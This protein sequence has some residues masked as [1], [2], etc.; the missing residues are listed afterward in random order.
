MAPDG[1]FDDG[2]SKASV[3]A[4][5]G[6]RPGK[7]RQEPRTAFAEPDAR[8]PDGGVVW[9]RVSASEVTRAVLVALVTAAVVLGSFLLLWEVRSFVGWFVISLFLAAALDPAVGWLQRRHGLIGR[10][11]ATC[12]STWGWRSPCSSWWVSSCPCWWTRSKVSSSSSP[13]WPGRPRG[14]RRFCEA[15]PNVTG[16]AGCSRGSATNSATRAVSW[17]T[18]SAT[19]SC[20]PVTSSPAPP[21][22]SPRW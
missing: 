19:F 6:D 8:A 2:A 7:T 13:P 18:R 20:P 1:T 10:T 14:R 3:G 16:L 5:D 22:L 9:V 4:G 15:S 17:G 12:S 11:L 21:A